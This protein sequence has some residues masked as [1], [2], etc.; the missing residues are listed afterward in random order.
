MT[1]MSAPHA[2]APTPAPV[3][4]RRCSAARRA[5]LARAAV[6]FGLLWASAAP[7]AP[8][9]YGDVGRGAFGSMSWV[10]RD[11]HFTS[12]TEYH[13][14]PLQFLSAQSNAWHL[15]YADAAM[16]GQA[17]SS[18][19][20]G[21]LHVSASAAAWGPNAAPY[22]SSYIAG[23]GTAI[24]DRITVGA[25]EGTHL[26][27]LRLRV[28]GLIDDA[29]AARVRFYVG[30]SDPFTQFALQPYQGWR[31][32]NGVSGGS[33]TREWDVTFE[34]GSLLIDSAYNGWPLNVYFEMDAMAFSAPTSGGLADFSH[35]ARFSWELPA[36]VTVQSASG[37]F[38]QGAPQA[39]PE[40]ASAALALLG[41]ALLPAL[42]RRGARGPAARADASAT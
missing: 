6:A 8:L 37:R 15:S 16:S 17:S 22:A 23:A 9:N 11:Y 18:L 34:L 33:G 38:M 32:L 29:A 39:V 41:L 42:R 10:T 25:D 26:I 1:A 20:D 4:T 35:T 36:G 21:S 12:V 28:D 24:W 31:H 7:A 2:T 30:P 14:G 5:G 13:G 19:L 3:S 27:P 40:P